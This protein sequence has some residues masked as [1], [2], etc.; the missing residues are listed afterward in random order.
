MVSP[1]LR[2]SSHCR[3]QINGLA[4]CALSPSGGITFGRVGEP[5]GTAD[6]VLAVAS[7]RDLLA[8]KV[9]VALRL[10]RSR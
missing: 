6:R 9:K 10:S 2:L 4:G 8:R 3:V 7:L 5:D 1:A